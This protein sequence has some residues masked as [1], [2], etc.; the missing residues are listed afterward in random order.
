MENNNYLIDGPISS[1]FVAEQIDKHGENHSSG[2]LAFFIG[3]VRADHN[4][5]KTVIAIE[6]SAFEAL[7]RKAVLV[8]KKQL[9][10]RY[11]DLSS[12]SIFHSTGLVK[13]GEVSLLVIVSCGHR[14]QAFLA[15][16]DCVEQIKSHLPI[17]KKELYDDSSYSWL[18]A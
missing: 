6:Y 16:E 18:K 10:E 1:A 5:T 11:E 14:K 12:V 3:Q 9:Y 13:T 8:I 4:N 15:M 2:A 17:W 7:V